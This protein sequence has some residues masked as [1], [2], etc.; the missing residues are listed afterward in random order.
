MAVSSL[1]ESVGMS[2]KFRYYYRIGI[3]SVMT[4]HFDIITVP[5]CEQSANFIVVC[6][7]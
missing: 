1:L 3:V 4:G 7:R 6:N 2:F 5:I